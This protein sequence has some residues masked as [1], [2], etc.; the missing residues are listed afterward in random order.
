MRVFKNRLPCLGLGGLSRRFSRFK[1]QL[2]RGATS[3]SPGSP[4]CLP[5]LVL[6]LGGDSDG[7]VQARDCSLQN[8]AGRAALGGSGSAPQPDPGAAAQLFTCC[9]SD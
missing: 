3:I 7:G 6:I 5:C 1:V 2:Q 4:P 8:L 9:K